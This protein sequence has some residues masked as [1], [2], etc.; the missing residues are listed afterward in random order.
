[1]E[2]PKIYPAYQ[3]FYN[4]ILNGKEKNYTLT[5]KT[6]NRIS[7][8]FGELA[9]PKTLLG[10]LFFREKRPVVCV[11]HVGSTGYLLAVNRKRIEELGGS[12]RD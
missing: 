11:G 10:R 2:E 7:V 8:H 4:Q 6:P 1:M 12:L 9:L 3:N 5:Q